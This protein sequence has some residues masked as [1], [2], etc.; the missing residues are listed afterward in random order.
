MRHFRR[1]HS[2]DI[3]PP[4]ILPFR[5]QVPITSLIQR[6]THVAVAAPANVVRDDSAPVSRPMPMA[7]PLPLAEAPPSGPGE[8]TRIIGR[9]NAP[10]GI[11]IPEPSVPAATPPPQEAAKPTPPAQEAA[12]P[13]QATKPPDP[14][15]APAAEKSTLESLVPILLVVN[16]FLLLLILLVT[17]FG[18]KNR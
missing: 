13:A 11:A 12:K 15:A 10:A 1:P 6:I 5:I 18:L 4:L 8:Y 2:P 7:A 16:T 3:Q 14:P 17:V 9:S